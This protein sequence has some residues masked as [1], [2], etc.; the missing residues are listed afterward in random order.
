MRKRLPHLLA[1]A[2]LAFSSGPLLSA[3]RPQLAS[4]PPGL[5][6]TLGNSAISL[7]GPWKFSPGDSSWTDHSP[8]WA[9]P[10]FDDSAWASLDLTPPAGSF[11]P[12]VGIKGFT[13]GWTR[14]GYP[15]LTGFAWYRLRLRVTDPGQ[16]LW[17]KM[18]D[19]F[20]DAYQVY[21]N[22]QYVGQF[23]HFDPQRVTFYLSQPASFQLPQL[24][25]DGQLDLAVR[26]Y[27]NPATPFHL[28]SAGGMH[29]PPV[30]G[31]A[32]AI[33]LLQRSTRDANLH[34]DFGHLLVAFLFLIVMPLAIWAWTLD[35]RELAW[36][37]LLLALTVQIV[38]A[39]VNTAAVLSTTITAGTAN[40]WLDVI[41]IPLRQI[42][43]ILFWW[44]WFR[45][46]RS[47]WIPIAAALLTAAH[48]FTRFEALS[49]IIR[50][51]SATPSQLSFF[52]T[53]SI[54][55]L[56]AQ[57][58]VLLIVLVEGFRHHREEALAAAL[59]ILLFVVAQFTPFI[60][61]A[62]GAHSFLLPFGLG[63]TPVNIEHILMIAVIGVL[64]A[65]RFFRSSVSRE[66]SHQAIERDLEQARELQLR[67]LVPEGLHSPNFTVE[68]EYHAAQVIGGDFFY[69]VLGR[70]G[71][72]CLV[73][74][75]VSGKGI[76][77]AMLV[78][79]LVGAARTRTSQDFDPIALLHTLDEC[80]AGR[81]GG[82]F[83]TCLAAQFL[84]DGLLR[85]ANAGHLPPYLN[86][87]EL[88]VDGSLPLG[89]AGNHTPTIKQ[90]SLRQ[91]D[92]LTFITDGV[93][94]AKN[95]RGELF[96]FDQA[97]IISQRPPA[98]IVSEVQAYGQEDDVTVLRVSFV[99]AEQSVPAN[100]L[101]VASTRV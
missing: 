97:R 70:D 11:D 42:F 9:Q 56:S 76:S 17:L 12:N 80:L 73:I 50:N 49:P 48:I 84:P 91:G 83:V 39:F 53:A 72:L 71:S 90:L 22:G 10:G 78:A 33:H 29:Q 16:Q 46:G 54:V 74:G 26:V 100:S 65:R 87:C 52:N 96:G 41:F 7:N 36:L 40:L 34:Y 14:R 86:G 99:H 82:H 15:N 64:A 89:I 98:D 31:L 88:D 69:T 18:S 93:V 57:A 59:P 3:S 95:K 25:S 21:A 44:S 30:I 2:L 32:P 85:I 24:P 5:T 20:D 94:E 13:P 28:P 4:P 27:M 35:H 8:D 38:W 19:D 67:V 61:V 66:L 81:T 60:V 79:V 92:M 6:I 51:S 23:G 37:W 101:S 77:A 75:D 63:I 1:A 47:R 55:I 68:A 62:S 58:I 45:L 43:W